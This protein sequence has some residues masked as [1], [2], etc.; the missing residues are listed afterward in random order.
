MFREALL[1]LAWAQT[2]HL[3]AAQGCSPA[4]PTTSPESY[5]KMKS[6]QSC[7]VSFGNHS[8]KNG[9]ESCASMSRSLKGSGATPV[10]GFCEA[11]GTLFRAICWKKLRPSFKAPVRINCFE[12]QNLWSH[13]MSKSFGQEINFGR[14]L[15]EEL[16]AGADLQTAFFW[17]NFLGIG[18]GLR[19][20]IEELLLGFT[21]KKNFFV[22]PFGAQILGPALQNWSGQLFCWKGLQNRAFGHHLGRQASTPFA[23]Y[24]FF[25]V[26]RFILFPYF[27]FKRDIHISFHIHRYCLETHNNHLFSVSVRLL[28]QLGLKKKYFECMVFGRLRPRTVFISRCRAFRF[29]S[30]QWLLTMK[31]FFTPA[32]SRV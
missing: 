14:T 10:E 1:K 28:R 19:D 27:A 2:Q 29:Y 23:G 32:L 20:K 8:A 18:F 9:V 3:F 12:E 24:L 26:G 25:L 5:P 22:C 15:R 30:K 4:P 17:S 21:W 7:L 11:V 13:S 16:W 6:A 31:K